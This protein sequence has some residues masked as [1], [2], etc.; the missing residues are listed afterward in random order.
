MTIKW[1]MLPSVLAGEY[2]RHESVTGRL[3]RERFNDLTVQGGSLHTLE[4]ESW[5]LRFDGICQLII[6]R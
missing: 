3:K 4:S 2:I 5:T 6:E 1:A